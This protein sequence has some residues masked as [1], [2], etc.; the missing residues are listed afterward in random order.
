MKAK[1]K[2]YDKG[3][4]IKRPSTAATKDKTANVANPVIRE[5]TTENLKN[6]DNQ[7]LGRRIYNT[8]Y[9]SK[10]P[11]PE[12]GFKGYGDVEGATKMETEDYYAQ[13]RKEM[14]IDKI[15]TYKKGGKVFKPHNMYKD[16]KK[17][18]AKT[19]ADHLR[20][21]KKGYSHKK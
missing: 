19:M 8:A 18:V 21:K 15:K 13:K 11:V 2:I 3:G 20:L 10:S 14:G 7:E 5:K 4:K 6:K 1:K 9:K 17:V 16:G 12:R